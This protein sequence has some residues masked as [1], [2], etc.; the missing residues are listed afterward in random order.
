MSR[1]ALILAL[2]LIGGAGS[3]AAARL[4]HPSPMPKVAV[5]MKSVV[6]RAS[7][8][9]FNIAGEADP[10][11]GA[12][13]KLPDVK[14]WAAVQADAARLRSI[15]LAMQ[16]P[17]T[18]KVGEINWMV[19]SRAMASASAAIEQAAA[20]RAPGALANAANDLSDTCSACHA[21]YKK[22]K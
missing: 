14:G 8:D 20:L 13:Q 19:Q 10:A 6:D 4:D 5:L 15:A 11:N 22:Q 12:D 17:S 1:P 9:I 18:G 16:S 21:V 2:V 7:T 3:T